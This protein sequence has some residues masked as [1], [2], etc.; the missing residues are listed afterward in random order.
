MNTA[1]ANDTTWAAQ[2]LMLLRQFGQHRSP[3]APANVFPQPPMDSEPSSQDPDYKPP[4]PL[5]D[6]GVASQATPTDLALDPRTLRGWPGPIGS[7]T[8]SVVEDMRRDL[9]V[10]RQ[11]SLHYFTPRQLSPAPPEATSVWQG[12][13]ASTA[14]RAVP[15][16][17][18]TEDE[19]NGFVASNPELQDMYARY[20]RQQLPVREAPPRVPP[21]ARPEAPLGEFTAQLIA[22]HAAAGY[23]GAPMPPYA[24]VRTQTEYVGPPPARLPF[25]HLAPGAP[26]Y[27][28]AFTGVPVRPL[29]TSEVCA[30]GPAYAAEVPYRLVGDSTPRPASY[31]ALPPRPAEALRVEPPVPVATCEKAPRSK[32]GRKSRDTPIRPPSPDDA[33][34]CTGLARIR[35]IRPKSRSSSSDD[36][37]SDSSVS[38]APRRKKHGKKSADS[39]DSES[40][41]SDDE[42]SRRGKS[43]R[44]GGSH[45]S[46]RSKKSRSSGSMLVKP[47][48]PKNFSGVPDELIG[49]LEIYESYAIAAGVPKRDWSRLVLAFLPDDTRDFLR[50]ET[51]TTKLPRFT[52]MRALLISKFLGE[53]PETLY[54]R[55]VHDATQRAAEP[56][57]RYAMRF[58][59]LVDLA[60]M[61][62]NQID[63]VTAVV[64]FIEG[65]RDDQTR[66][67]LNR[68][69]LGDRRVREKSG[70]EADISL[71][72]DFLTLARSCE[73][74]VD[75]LPSK[76][77]A[78]ALVAAVAVSAPEAIE[79]KPPTKVARPAAPPA[80]L[81]PQFDMAELAKCLAPLMASHMAATSSHPSTSA[82]GARRVRDMTKVTCFNCNQKGHFADHCSSARNDD[83]IGQR[84]NRYDTR[85]KPGPRGAAVDAA[86][87]AVVAAAAAPPAGK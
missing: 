43:S 9:Q 72:D 23:S 6:F 60:N 19:W 16:V 44:K 18:T 86:P 10:A 8:G 11:A 30:A 69:R 68:E 67:F 13:A 85:F 37:A 20:A 49:W 14:Q 87:P 79:P 61:K 41:S 81:P 5:V 21:M 53:D 84:K 50:Y 56:M 25:M 51:K 82:D 15:N 75:H 33:S 63:P 35:K 48:R 22:H 77:D 2:A 54:G 31:G 64:K 71:L 45:K 26:V 59:R 32:H 76:R 65:V 57:L 55:L 70:K 83:L 38:S 1:V 39:S 58:R 12:P 52:A 3:P 28:S 27:P 17:I 46:S 34:R 24:A 74:S 66:A 40:G 7:A 42:S 80:A 62:R 73:S 78:P 47:P 29:L 36:S 4:S